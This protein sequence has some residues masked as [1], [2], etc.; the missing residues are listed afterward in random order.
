MKKRGAAARGIRIAFSNSPIQLL[1]CH[2]RIDADF[3][4][5]L[6]L[7][8]EFNQAVRK[9]EDGV[10]PAHSDIVSRMKLRAELPNYDVA[11]AHELTAEFLYAPALACTVAAIAGTST[12]F[13]MCHDIPPKLCLGVW[14][15][16]VSGF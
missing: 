1:T 10:I 7:I 9:C 11:G 6:V 14:G 5:R 15:P 3:L 8:F 12:R 13:F 4:T 16:R 2:C